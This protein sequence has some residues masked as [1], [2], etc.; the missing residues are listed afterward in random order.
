MG[1][2]VVHSYFGTLLYCKGHLLFTRTP[3]GVVSAVDEPCLVMPCP[4]RRL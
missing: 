1:A 3:D 4:A 2:T